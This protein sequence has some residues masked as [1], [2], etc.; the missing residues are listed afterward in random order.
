[1]IIGTQG[2]GVVLDA[3]MCAWLEQY[4]GLTRLRVRVRGTD[5]ALSQQLEEIRLAALHWRGSATG[6]TRA[7]EAEP[8]A[9]S[10]QWLSTGEAAELLGVTAR[11]VRKAIAEGRL[12]ATTLSN[13]HRRISREDLE[14]YRAAR[15]A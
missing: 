15:A 14:H 4:A 3:R 2:P 12:S 5:P 13:R 11:A 7:T 8:A 1:M 9:R 6:T 10:E